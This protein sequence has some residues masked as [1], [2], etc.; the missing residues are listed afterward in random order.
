MQTIEPLESRIAPATIYVLDQNGSLVSFDSESPGTIESVPITGLGAAQTLRGIDFR[1]ATGELYGIAATTGSAANS[2][3][4]TYIIDRVTGV[5]TLVGQTATAIAGWADVP[6]GMDFNPTVD[7]IRVV[8]TND[9]NFRVN[10]TNAALAGNDTD[11]T[12]AATSDIIGEAYDRSFV[13]GGLATLFGINRADGT[14]VLQGGVDGSPS[15]NGGVITSVGPLGLTLNAV[16]DGGF[17]IAS[18]SG[19]AYAALTSSAD[20]LTRLYTIN[21]TTGAATAVGLIGNGATGVRGLSVELPGV[22]IVNSKTAT[23]IDADGDRVKIKVSK[24]TL[25]TDNFI[26]SAVADGRG[27][28]TGL[29]LVG[30]D[31]DEANLRISVKKAGGGDGL[32]HVGFINA[33]GTDL[34]KLSIKGDLGRITAGDAIDST[35]GLAALKVKSLGTLG[36]VTQGGRGSVS[37]TITGSIDSLKVGGDVGNS[38]LFAGTVGSVSVRGD[39]FGVIFTSGDITSFRVSGD[40][41]G[42]E[43]QRGYINCSKLG[44]AFIGG[45]LIG[46][47]GALSGLL[48][49]QSMGTIHIRGDMVA[50]SGFATGGVSAFAFTAGLASRIDSVR[51]D[52]DV[53]GGDGPI[54]AYIHSQFGNPMSSSDGIGKIVIGGDFIGGGGNSSGQIQSEGSVGEVT[55]RG[56]II[57]NNAF[58]GVVAITGDLEKLNVGRDIIGSNSS[59]SGYVSATGTIGSVKIGGNLAGGSV[60]STLSVANSGAIVGG[61][62]ASVRIA[63]SVIAGSNIGTGV[64]TNSGTI[65][66]RGALGAVIIGGSIVGNSTN[67][68]NIVARGAAM[69]TGDADVAIATIAVKGDVEFA[70]VLA[71]FDEFLAPANADASIGKIKVGGDWRASSVAAGAQDTGNLGFGLGDTLQP[72]GSPTAIAR[73]ASI[74]VNGEVTGSLITG[75]HFGFV[76]EQID[77]IKIGGRSVNL[78]DGASNDNVLISFTDDVRILEVS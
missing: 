10:P 47:H 29:T 62:I 67:P 56:S 28:L 40:V 31:F 71:G 51:I 39:F 53:I 34:G 58:T 16:N 74:T 21:L 17:D 23:F 22:K 77:S 8:N 57:G 73:I 63:G 41:I 70:R 66:S 50:G 36:L 76:A 32:A 38:E 24:G 2:V 3:A 78:A 72:G 48:Q 25:T 61:E 26:L 52:G 60:T 64:L 59:S 20:N 45:S 55:I 5:A 68:V 46:G 7:R 1:P 35:P 9:E 54:S 12:P 49:A 43:A 30:A 69:V 15:P 11:L 4:F 13:G 33:A 44:S 18:D 65:V 75:D 42:V 6:T 19:I 27:S 14:L 37:S